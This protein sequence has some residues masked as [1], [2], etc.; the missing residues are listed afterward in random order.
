LT[1]LSTAQADTLSPGYGM[2]SLRS[3]APDGQFTAYGGQIHYWT[4]SGGYQVYN[5]SSGAT[6]T[7]GLP[8]NGTITNN[9]GDAFGVLDPVNNV[10]YAATVSN[11]G[12]YIYEYDRTA[13]TWSNSTS[14]G[15]YLANA[16]GGQVY[17][18]QLYV[19]GLPATWTGTPGNT[20]I[21]VFS[22]TAIRNEAAPQ[23]AIQASGYSADLAVAPDGDVYYGTNDTDTLY[24]W[25][26]AQVAA[27]TS[28]PLSLGNA[29]NQWNLPGDGGG[30]AVDAAG[31]VFFAVNNFN[32][33]DSTLA[34]LDSKAPNGYDPIYMSDNY[35]DYFGAIS[36]DGDFLHGG[37]LYFNPGFNEGGTN[38]LL[39]IQAVPEPGTS[40][41]LAAGLALVLAARRWRRPRTISE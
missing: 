6:T 9:F 10:F 7:I 22:N 35:Q 34:M 15:V 41:L 29:T 1:T 30:L 24:R 16:F 25:T 17:N 39:A 4:S 14:A 2:R 40:A 21:L 12:S 13:G 26:A 8:P 19:S 3:V 38:S 36:V 11:S 5:T 31:N 28:T 32:T 33:G 20:D 23:I 18:G 27:V 37:S